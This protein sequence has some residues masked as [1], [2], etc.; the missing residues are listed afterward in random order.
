S[1]N[2]PSFSA[3][4]NNSVIFTATVTSF[5]GTVNTGTVTFASNGNMLGSGPVTVSNGTAVLNTSFASTGAYT[6]LATYNGN[7]NFGS[8]RSPDLTKEV[9]SHTATTL[10]SDNNPS[11][12]TD[13]GSLVNFTA[14]VTSAGSPVSGGTVSFTSNGTSLGGSASVVGGTAVLT[15]IFPT[16]GTY[17]IQATYSGTSNFGPSSSSLSQ[18]VNSHPI[19]INSI[20]ANNAYAKSGT[21]QF[22]AAFATSV[23]GL[24]ASNFSLTT[25][26]VS[27]A[28]VASVSPSSGSTY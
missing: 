9:I 1:S 8:S 5:S 17:N 25:S 12:S 16:A 22:M 19:A 20:T 21:I 2:N 18:Q 10:S 7:S 4:P 13:P 14:T 23:T 24:S 3:F 6:I 28:S 15:T 11:F 26:G 27:G